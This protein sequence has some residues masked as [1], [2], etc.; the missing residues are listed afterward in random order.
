[1]ISLDVASAS[2]MEQ[3]APEYYWTRSTVDPSNIKSILAL[4]KES[5]PDLRRANEEDYMK[6]YHYVFCWSTGRK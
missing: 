4:A 3:V 2:M 1:M 5:Y 6:K